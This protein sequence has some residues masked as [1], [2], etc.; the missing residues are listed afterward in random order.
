ML[1]P[2]G[3]CGDKSA[4]AYPRRLNS[5]CF[6]Y[7]CVSCSARRSFMSRRSSRAK[8]A[9]AA[10]NTPERTRADKSGKFLGLSRH[11]FPAVY[12]ERFQYPDYIN[13]LSKENQEW[14][15]RFLD[16]ETQGRFY[17][18]GW[19][20]QFSSCSPYRQKCICKKMTC[21]KRIQRE[22]YYAR[23]DIY[24]SKTLGIAPREVKDDKQ[25]KKGSLKTKLK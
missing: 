19:G 5:R 15:A 12:Q 6:Q 9:G 2:C 13:K 8:S 23:R 14:L 4:H 18:D 11:D 24:N 17:D 3:K 21:K 20:P 1:T 10:A 16:A 25:G 7:L 22:L